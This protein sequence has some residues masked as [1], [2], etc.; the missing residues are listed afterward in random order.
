MTTTIFTPEVHQVFNE[1]DKF[2]LLLGLQRLENERN[3]EYKQRLLDV[4]VHRSGSSYQGLIHGITRELGLSIFDAFTIEPR[5]DQNGNNI[6]TNPAVIFSETKCDIYSD[7]TQETE[8]FELSIDRFDTTSEGYTL[9]G[10]ISLINSTGYF[11]CN[12]LTGVSGNIRSM[13]IFNQSTI[14]TQAAENLDTGGSRIKLKYNNLVPNSITIR[15]GSL[16]ERVDTTLLL[17]KAGQYYIDSINGIIYCT[18]VP[19]TG[20]TIR[21]QYWKPTYMVAASPVIMHTLHSPDFRSKMFE[22]GTI[23][24]VT[25]DGAITPLGA[26]L[27]NELLSV[28]PS[29]WGP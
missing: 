24:G 19:S 10:L 8:G 29:G 9:S 21:Y 27:V 5:K 3:A 14:Y 12:L 1:L 22:Q 2:G 15:S 11:N 7:F 28:F 25:T 18:S 6:A 23:N 17:R 16:V 4:F 13:T 20:S 26:E